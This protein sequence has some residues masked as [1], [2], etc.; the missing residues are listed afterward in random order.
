MILDE[1][2]DGLA[3]ADAAAAQQVRDLATRPAKASVS[4]EPAM[5]IA[6]LPGDAVA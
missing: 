1:D 3:R 6:S 2:G 4:P 5:T